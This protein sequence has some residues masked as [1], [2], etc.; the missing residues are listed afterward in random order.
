MPATNTQKGG[1]SAIPEVPQHTRS[2]RH[3]HRPSREVKREEPRREE[4]RRTY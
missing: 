3:S 4:S 1:R 2:R